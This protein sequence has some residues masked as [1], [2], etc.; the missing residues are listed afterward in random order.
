MRRERRS[1]RAPELLV[2]L[3]LRRLQ[4][5]RWARDVAARRSRAGGAGPFAQRGGRGYRSLG[6]RRRDLGRGHAQVACQAV[7]VLAQ[8]ALE[9]AAREGPEAL[10]PGLGRRGTAVRI[11]HSEG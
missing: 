7:Q 6:R 2:Q 8:D 11:P 1:T 3:T 10:A 9:E 5:L 4:G